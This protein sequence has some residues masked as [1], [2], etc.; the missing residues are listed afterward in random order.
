L[1][2]ISRPE[3]RRCPIAKASNEIVELLS[4]HWA[5]FAPGCEYFVPSPATT[6]TLLLFNV[7]STSTTFQPF[8]LNF[9]KVHALALNFCLRMWNES[10]A[11]TGDFTRVIALARSQ[12][13]LPT[14][15]RIVVLIHVSVE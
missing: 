5:I 10:G 12:C 13:V 3:E 1:E 6:Q 15:G 2:Q 9:Y 7:D 8:F 4:E 11:A 14:F